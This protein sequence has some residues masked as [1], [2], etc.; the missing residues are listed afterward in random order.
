MQSVQK[1][2]DSP[3]AVLGSVG[4]R[5]SLCNDRLYGADSA[6]TVEVPQLQYSDRVVDVPAAVHRQGLDVPVI[7]QRQVHADSRRCLRFSSSQKLDYD[8]S[9]GI[10]GAFCA[11]FRAPPV[12]RTSCA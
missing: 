8:G 4:T 11:I 7:L 2:G 1:T 5:P 3:G 6:E 12:I 10:F 9:D